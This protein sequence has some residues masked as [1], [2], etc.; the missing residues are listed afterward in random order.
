[1]L[2]SL[3]NLAR[4]IVIGWTLARHDALVLAQM[5]GIAPGLLRL[6][7]LLARGGIEGRPGQKLAR[8]FESL[9]PSFI[10]LGQILSTRSD[11]IGE[12]VAADLAMLRDSLPP[13][14]AAEARAIV[15]EELAAPIEALYQRFD[16]APVAAASIA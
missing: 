16:D 2:R 12:E 6:S 3:R 10:K 13:F 4:L 9:G 11:L 7:R 1:M 15:A 14:P 5:A 8:A